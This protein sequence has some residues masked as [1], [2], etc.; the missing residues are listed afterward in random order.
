MVELS[1]P[2]RL[3]RARAGAAR[4]DHRPF[5]LGVDVGTGSARA[6]LFDH[7]RAAGRPRRAPD[8]DLVSPRRTH[9]EQSSDDIWHAVGAATRCARGRGRACGRAVAGIGFD[10]TCSLVALDAPG[11]PVTV[12]PTATT[13]GTSSCGWTTARSTT[14]GP[15]TRP[16]IRCCSSSAVR[17]RPRWRRRSCGGCK[18]EPAGHVAAGRALVRP[19]RLPDVARDRDQSDRSLCSDRVQVDIPRARAPVG[20]VVLRAR[21]DSATS[22][23]T[24]SRA[25]AR[26]CACPGERVGDL[27][28][29]AAA[30]PRVC[31]RARR[32]ACRSSTR[33]PARSACSARPATTLRSTTGSR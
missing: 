11:A 31:A 29:A 26:A 28:D 10:A 16:G 9:V 6:G 25:S 17:S 4:D 23:P 14:R 7:R 24:A 15:S 8:R 12:S 22:P 1:Q 2:P 18:R 19:A 27:D 5:V 3:P 33:T 20:C 30:R 21:S 32:S 13:S